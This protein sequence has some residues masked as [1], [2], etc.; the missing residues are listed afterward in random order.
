MCEPLS[1]TRQIE[2]HLDWSRSEFHGVIYSIENFIIGTVL[3]VPPLWA[4]GI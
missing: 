2:I 4:G 3:F 1:K